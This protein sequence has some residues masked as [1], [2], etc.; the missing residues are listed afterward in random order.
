LAF[1]LHTLHNEDNGNIREQNKN[2][3]Y[4]IN[5]GEEQA[6]TSKEEMLIYFG[7]EFLPKF[8]SYIS[9]KFLGLMKT[10][11]ICGIC[12][13]NTYSFD[14][15]FFITFDL[16]KILIVGQNMMVGGLDIQKCFYFQNNYN[17][18]TEKY[19]S[20]CLQRTNH[21]EFKQ[22]YSCP[23]LLIIYIHVIILDLKH[24]TKWSNLLILILRICI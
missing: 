6:K 10:K 18:M 17:K 13:I 16:E 22:F 5:S 7:N 2:N 20:K 21:I 12:K 23:E 19:C 8:N 3:Q 9:K 15:S 14:S 1:L 24:M 11:N 4:Y